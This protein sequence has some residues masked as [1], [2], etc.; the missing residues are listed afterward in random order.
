MTSQAVER[1]QGPAAAVVFSDREMKSIEFQAR[2]IIALDKRIN[3]DKELGLALAITM[4]SLGI[5]V[6]IT[7]A[8]KLHIIN[9]EVVESSQLLVGLLAM[10]GHEVRVIEEGDECAVV[11]GRRHGV[12]DPHRVTYTIDQARRSGALDEWVE[13]WAATSSGKKYPQ[14][15]YLVFEGEPNPAAAEPWAKEL[16]AKHDI[17]RMDAWHKFRSDMLVNRAIRRLAKRMGG[18]AL[19]GVGGP[20]DDSEPRPPAPRPDDVIVGLDAGEPDEP[21][22]RS[23]ETPQLGD[24]ADPAAAHRNECSK[25]HVASA[26]IPAG[27]WRQ[28]WAKAWRE[29]GLPPSAG[30]LE[31]EQLELARRIT[32]QFLALASLDSI[33]LTDKKDRHD[34]VSAAT[35]GETE[36]TKAL[37]AEQLQSVR[38]A[39][40]AEAERREAAPAAAALPD[41]APQYGPDEEPF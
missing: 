18:D 35:N 38:T 19:L 8:K 16:I 11:E 33:G 9:G 32:R 41:E 15:H 31:V 2:A 22:S 6:T 1:H 3:G 28:L 13:K 10:H 34:F 21:S 20:L 36:S 40:R 4:Y 30:K 37:T 24:E 17:K 23:D 26:A 39:C 25:V 29:A 7:N 14:R 27:T 5:P 12:G